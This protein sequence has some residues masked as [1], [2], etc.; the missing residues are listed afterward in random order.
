MVPDADQ[1]FFDFLEPSQAAT[2]TV[3]DHFPS[4]LCDNLFYSMTNNIKKC[5]YFDLHLNH[6][7]ID[8]NYSLI[9]LHVNIRSLHKNF[10]LLHE[11]LVTLNFSTDIICL[12]ETRLKSEPLINIELPHYKFLHVDTTTT[13]GGVAIYSLNTLQCEP[14]PV[15]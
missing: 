5:K 14:C 8:K 1:E 3:D 11:F 10:K 4:E 6:L 13:A 12:T 2:Q 9:L 15:Q 7:K